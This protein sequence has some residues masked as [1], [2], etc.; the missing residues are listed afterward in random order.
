MYAEFYQTYRKRSGLC[1]AGD[2]VNT[3]LS[4]VQKACKREQGTPKHLIPCDVLALVCSSND[5]GRLK[6]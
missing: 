2:V 5:E 3:N 1:D 6:S 4:P